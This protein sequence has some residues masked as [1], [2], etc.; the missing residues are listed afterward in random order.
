MLAA[1]ESWVLAL[2]GEYERSA[3]LFFSNEADAL[4]ASELTGAWCVPVKV[5]G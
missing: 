1:P 2:V 5:A 3:P 4:T